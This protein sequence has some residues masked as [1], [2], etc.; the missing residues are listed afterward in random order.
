VLSV[1]FKV[2]YDLVVPPADLF[3]VVPQLGE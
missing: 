2:G 3:S 1:G